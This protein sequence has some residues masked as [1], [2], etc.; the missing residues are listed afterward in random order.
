MDFLL[1]QGCSMETSSAVELTAMTW[2]RAMV[3]D[4][5]QA[6]EPQ[7]FRAHP[8]IEIPSDWDSALHPLRSSPL[9]SLCS[10]LLL[11]PASQLD[12]DASDPFLAY[13][14]HVNIDE[15]IK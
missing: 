9:A 6:V 4:M 15:L 8:V 3:R 2:V 10:S 14:T 13:M 1:S 11:S 7:F 5:N 12:G